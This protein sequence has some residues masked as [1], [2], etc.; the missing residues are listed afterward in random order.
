[1]KEL[2]TW[3]LT[4]EGLDVYANQVKD[5]LFDSLAESSIITKEKAEELSKTKIIINKKR[6]T[7]SRFF[8]KLFQSDN[9][10]HYIIVATIT[11][12]DNNEHKGS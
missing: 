3:T 4:T 9:E 6:S 8:K 7:L 5:I 11:V 1:M 10:S 12:G 2:V